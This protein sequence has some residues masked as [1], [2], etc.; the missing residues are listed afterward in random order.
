KKL[1]S[2]K[3]MAGAIAHR[4]NNAMV[5][6][7]G[8]LQLLTLYLPDSSKE[9][10]MASRA[11]LAAKGASQIGSSMLSYVGQQPLTPREVSLVEVVRE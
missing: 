9:H 10:V 2:L 1:A 7:Q 4:F 11:F 3:N 8:N 5:A 6:V